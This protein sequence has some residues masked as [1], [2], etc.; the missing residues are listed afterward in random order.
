MKAKVFTHLLDGGRKV[1]GADGLQAEIDTIQEAMNVHRRELAET[2][3]RR[4]EL[5]L[6][7]NP[8][9][10]LDQLEM[11][12]RALYRRLERGTMQITALEARLVEMRFAQIQPRI[13]FHQDQLRAASEQVEVAVQAAMKANAAAANAFADAV[14]ELGQ[15]DAN[16]LMP[17]VGFAGVLS[18]EGLEIWRWKLNEQNERIA[19]QH[20]TARP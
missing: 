1:A 4:A 6:G 15:N 11:V 12:E 7:D 16:R 3:T 10:E 13:D 5:L 18:D 2:P 20:S 19:H 17:L 14:A 9:E 8:D